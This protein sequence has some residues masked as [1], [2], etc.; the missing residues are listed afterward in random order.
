MNYK[1]IF[2]LLVV[3]IL[4]L[5][6]RKLIKSE[7]FFR[8]TNKPNIIN[9]N[10]TI[11]IENKLNNLFKSISKKNIDYTL[12]KSKYTFY[13]PQTTPSY[14]LE[15]LK[16]LSNYVLV[17]LNQ[18]GNKLF[19]FKYS[20]L[21]TI[22]VYEV[23][24][25]LKQF[26]Y[27]LFI[28]DTK[29]AFSLKLN[30]NILTY[31]QKIEIPEFISQSTLD[32][33]CRGFEHY[34]IGTPSLEQYIPDPMNVIPSGNE[35]I[36]T[37]GINYPEMKQKFLKGLIL[38]ISIG[39]STLVLKPHED[40]SLLENVFS[41]DKTV[42]ENAPTNG[43][44]NPFYPCAKKMNEWITLPEQPINKGD[45]PCAKIPFKWNFLGCQP[46]PEQTPDCSGPT[47][48]TEDKPI[49]AQFWRSNYGVPQN[50]SKFNW[51][52]NRVNASGAIASSQSQ[53][54]P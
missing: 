3:I 51:L 38:N 23:E 37:G 35:V 32:F 14:L 41:V 50:G 4:L 30:V 9:E 10:K 31:N 1:I 39:E 49:N 21:G 52:F 16:Q 45:W 11:F 15:Y 33:E 12:E 43:S 19:N 8:N 53:P 18:N 48:R 28:Y 47:S 7:L 46:E 34:F 44:K 24:N 27:E 22:K 36:G 54:P 40:T 13:I 5:I 29:N 42:L 20:N 17:V 26:I 25:N 6:N 2:L